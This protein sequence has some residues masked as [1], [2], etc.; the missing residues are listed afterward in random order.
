ML[1]NIWHYRYFICSAI[2]N[3]LFAQ[4]TRSKLGALWG[5]FNPLAQVLIYA[6]VLSHVLAARLPGIDH[7]FGFSI[8]LM[9]GMLGFSLFS[10]IINRSVHL[11][12]ENANLIKKINFP[13]VTL[14]CIMLGSC[15]L[16]NTILFS[17]I[18]IIFSLFDHSFNMTI[19]WLIPLTGTIILFAFG[20]GLMLGVMN[21]FIR[22]ISQIVPIILQIMFWFTPIVY[23]VNIIPEEYL[24]LLMLNPL[25]PLIEAYHDVLLYGQAPDLM[26]MV[27]LNILGVMTLLLGI[28][29]FKRA[30]PEMVDVL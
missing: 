27:H 30:G 29:I 25:F 24:P 22:D 21:V 18:V 23:P 16:N 11:F 10:D 15:L 28:F 14:P 12:L 20:M 7:E 2:W 9:S 13:R 4:F 26:S 3:N 8:Y 6:L 5:I 1:S 19:L 17:A